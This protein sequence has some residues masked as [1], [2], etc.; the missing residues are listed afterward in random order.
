[1]VSGNDKYLNFNG[2]STFYNISTPSFIVNKYHTIFAVERLQSNTAALGG[3]PLM[4]GTSVN[5]NNSNLQIVY[6]GTNMTFIGFDQWGGVG[7]QSANIPPYTTAAAQPTRL[8]SFSQLTSNRSIYLYGSTIA[9]NTNNT[10]LIGWNG[11]SIGFYSGAPPT[12]T[13]YYPGHYKEVLFY[14]GQIS[15]L[16]RQKV[17]GYLAWKW[18][19]QGSLSLTYPYK[20]RSPASNYANMVSPDGLALNLKGTNYS[21]SGPWGNVGAYGTN[22]TATVENGTP[23]LNV[24]G[25][26]VVFNGSTNF[27]MSNIVLGNAW[28]VSAWVKRTGTVINPIISQIWI[29]VDVNMAVLTSGGDKANAA[30]FT[31]GS[32][33]EALPV[34]LPL[35]TWVQISFSWNGTNFVSYSNAT[36]IGSVSRAFT[37]SDAGTNYVIGRQWDASNYINNIQIGQLLVYNR[38]I[39]SNEVIQNYN[40]TNNIFLV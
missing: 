35:N 18:G 26:G 24:A 14:T 3:F 21:G 31:G 17:E 10:L 25:N 32:W 19:L 38:V 40:V 12:Y 7:V 8:W 39:D 30:F 15:T 33:K 20:Y 5:V 9:T 28:S 2:V 36:T 16:E 13:G 22:L 27:R 34:T 29:G 4:G 6:Q 1:V 23:S 37:S 11:A